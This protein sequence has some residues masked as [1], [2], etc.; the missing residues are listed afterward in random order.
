MAVLG[1]GGWFT[2]L[3]GNR[4]SKP[5]RPV[6]SKKIYQFTRKAYKQTGGATPDL[7]RVYQT[8][9]DSQKGRSSGS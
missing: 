8:Y 1:E 6:Q 3:L 2:R 4:V 5:S 9:L 7:K